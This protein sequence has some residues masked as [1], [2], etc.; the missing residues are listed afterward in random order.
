MVFEINTYHKCVANKV[1]EVTQCTIAW[2]VDDNKLLHKNPE[3]ISYIINEVKKHF[4]ELSVLKENKHTFLGI[5]TYINNSKI[6]VDM[7]EQLEE[8]IEMFFEEVSTLVTSTA[9]NK[10]FEVW[11]DAEQLSEKK[12]EFSTQWWQSCYL[13]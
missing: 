2:Y 11:E 7:V 13:S 3:V 12:G 6:Q 1:L 8:S 5:N 10:L 9:T 4:G